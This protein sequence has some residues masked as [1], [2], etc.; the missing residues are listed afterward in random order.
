[1]AARMSGKHVENGPVSP[2]LLRLFAKDE[3]ILFNAREAVICTLPF[4][5]VYGVNQ[6]FLGAIKGL[7][8]TTW[9]MVCTLA[10]YSLFRVLWCRALIP[11]YPTMRGVYFSYVVC[12]FLMLAMLVPAYK[13]SFRAY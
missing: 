13:R 8:D 3:A 12:F 4:Y 10:C 7:G 6:V 9:P 1:M 11:A 2:V 5:V